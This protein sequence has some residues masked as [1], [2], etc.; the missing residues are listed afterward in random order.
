M[1][2]GSL[3]DEGFFR[4]VGDESAAAAAATVPVLVNLFRPSKVVDIGG[5][6]GAWGAALLRE[7]VPDVVTVDGDWV[8]AQSLLVPRDTFVTHDLTR[9]LKLH[10]RFDLVLCLEVGEHIPE[11]AAETFVAS[12]VTHG[13]LV[14]FSAAIPD[15]GGTQHVNEQWPSY[16]R[17]LFASRG[18]ELF[19][20][21]R[22]RLWDDERIVFWFRQNMLV[23]AAGAAADRVRSL[24]AVAA[25]VNVVHPGQFGSRTRQAYRRRGI[26]DSSMDLYH[27]VQRRALRTLRLAR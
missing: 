17:D 4:V 22:P 2:S 1:E 10:Q 13:E 24:P 7:G 20:I 23:F 11:F 9:P 12:L 16:W 15:Q 26:K 6:T 21:L 8:P 19:D 18:Y 27:A 25:P 3:Y 14:V 5:G